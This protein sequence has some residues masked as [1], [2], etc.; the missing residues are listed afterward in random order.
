MLI[1]SAEMRVLR[2][3]QAGAK[4]QQDPISINKTKAWWCMIAISAILDI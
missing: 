2:Y 3:W 1:I 4:S